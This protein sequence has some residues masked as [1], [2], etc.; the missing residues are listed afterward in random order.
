MKQPRQNTIISDQA[1]V[2]AHEGDT[3][4]LPTIEVVARSAFEYTTMFGLDRD[5]TLRT[6]LDKPNS[7][8]LD[9]PGSASS[10]GAQVRSM[11]RRAGSDLEVISADIVYN[12]KPQEIYEAAVATVHRC[13]DSL[14]DNG[15]SWQEAAWMS[16]QKPFRTPKDLL[17]HRLA[18][19][20]AY[21]EDAEAN[22]QQFI[23]ASLPDLTDLQGRTF[24]LILCGNLLFAYADQHFGNNDTERFDF[25]LKSIL[26][27]GSLLA[28]D[29]EVRIYPIGTATTREYPKLQQLIQQLEDKGF[30]LELQTVDAQLKADWDQVAIVRKV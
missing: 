10:F 8:I 5:K 9:C 4:S 3:L 13:L 11:A 30:S 6:L 21:L 26:S 16:E 24:N 18:I 28:P 15:N 23:S 20:K 22:P 25:H 7:C 2:A 17:E 27:F 12:H 19:Y 29:G 14:I 1:M